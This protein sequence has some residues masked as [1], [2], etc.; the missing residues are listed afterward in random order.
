MRSSSIRA[1]R[2]ALTVRENFPISVGSPIAQ[3]AERWTLT[4]K[5]L[6]STPSGAATPKDLISSIDLTPWSPEPRGGRVASSSLAGWQRDTAV[7]V[8]SWGRSRQT[9]GKVAARYGCRSLCE[10]SLN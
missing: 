9:D 5:V 1:C 8:C 10:T 3:L 4:P 7:R 2:S 6:G